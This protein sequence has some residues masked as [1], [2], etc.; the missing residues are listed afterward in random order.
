MNATLKQAVKEAQRNP[1]AI[2]ED[3]YHRA[4]D[5]MQ[6]IC[7]ICRD[8]TNYGVEGDAEGYTCEQCDNPTIIGTEDCLFHDAITIT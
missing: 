1:I 8:L 6:G 2:S 5:E 3:E 7:L 4:N